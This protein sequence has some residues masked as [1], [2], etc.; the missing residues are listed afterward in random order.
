[1]ET[2]DALFS[3]LKRLLLFI[4]HLFHVPNIQMNGWKGSNFCKY[5]SWSLQAMWTLSW[6]VLLCP[7]VLAFFV[8]WED[9]PFCFCGMGCYMEN[10]LVFSLL[11]CLQGVWLQIWLRREKVW[12]CF[13]AHIPLYCL[14]LC[15]YEQESL[16]CINPSHSKPQA[17]QAIKSL[18]II[19]P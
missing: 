2:Q 14:F 12:V 13:P 1:M 7:R 16:R 5:H 18:F 3:F 8:I 19:L 9:I 10:Q 4:Y 11:Q 17:L 15:V 6:H